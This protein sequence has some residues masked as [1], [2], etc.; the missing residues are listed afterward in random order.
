MALPVTTSLLGRNLGQLIG[1][2]VS[3]QEKTTKKQ[4]IAAV[5]SVL[6]GGVDYV[7]NK[8]ADQLIENLE[9]SEVTATAKLDHSYSNRKKVVD[10]KKA[11]N[12]FGAFG[13]FAS[14]AELAFNNEHQSVLYKYQQGALPTDI[15]YKD[16]WKRQWVTKVRLPLHTKQ[17]GTEGYDIAQ[18]GDISREE[19][20]NPSKAYHDAEMELAGAPW[21]RSWM[22][23]G[24]RQV[25]DKLDKI[26]P[27]Q[28]QFGKRNE[29]KLMTRRETTE[30][31]YLDRLERGQ[32]GDAL[33]LAE[34]TAY[35]NNT[36]SVDEDTV[37]L[38]LDTVRRQLIADPQ[39]ASIDPKGELQDEFV[40]E[41]KAMDEPDRTYGKYKAKILAYGINTHAK[42][43]M[44][45]V[46]DKTADIDRLYKTDDG[47]LKEGI[48][49][50]T[51]EAALDEAVGQALGLPDV[52][53]SR[54]RAYNQL[55]DVMK[56]TKDLGTNER[57]K[58]IDS[59][60]T[61][62]ALTELVGISPAQIRTEQITLATRDYYRRLE[63]EDPV[64]QDII[65]NMPI[66]GKEQS[67]IQAKYPE[68]KFEDTRGFT[69]GGTRGWQK[70][71]AEYAAIWE[72][73][74]NKYLLEKEQEAMTIAD[75]II[76]RMQEKAGVSLQP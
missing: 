67:L 66:T 23:N 45:R 6:F 71:R 76:K 58:I 8:K 7:K 1:G 42:L 12:T 34:E 52:L 20:I 46:E 16:D 40:S 47:K 15:A 53:A 70:E 26:I 41:W 2:V 57:E 4:K 29:E 22:H 63:T 43:N 72:Y 37:V 64:M 28:I 35:I 25:G 18:Y 14:D 49:Q 50:S 5:L 48:S 33:G 19:F 56:G 39:F 10:E 62:F 17:Y 24:L 69:I 9:D 74:S 59:A 36:F 65:E 13:A 68:L 55:I 73:K 75:H 38:N 27:D 32:V 51:Y 3:D 60:I 31:L 44:S 11:I 61:D 30:Q 21:K 54:K